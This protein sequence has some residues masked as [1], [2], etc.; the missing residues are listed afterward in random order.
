MSEGKELSD[1]KDAQQGRDYTK[2][3]ILSLSCSLRL[4]DGSVLPQEW[5]CF[6]HLYE[7]LHI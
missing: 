2:N 4:T 1:L 3:C 5:Y 7:F 6:R